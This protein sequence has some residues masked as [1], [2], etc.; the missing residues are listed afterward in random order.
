[1]ALHVT[2]LQEA[3]I[4][5]RIEETDGS[6]G[7][8]DAAA[9]AGG[10]VAWVAASVSSG[11]SAGR[12]QTAYP[13]AA[14]TPAAARCPAHGRMNDRARAAAHCF[15]RAAAH[16]AAPSL[17]HAQAPLAAGGVASETLPRLVHSA[18]HRECSAFVALALLLLR[19]A[20]R[21]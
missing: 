17:V 14:H 6:G 16:G 10:G 3:R 1:M 5:A 20:E 7:G 19:L 12:A 15:R 13:E 9:R 11:G 2:K 8:G 4:V 18:S 21:C